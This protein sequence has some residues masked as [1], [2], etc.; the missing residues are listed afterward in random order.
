MYNSDSGIRS[1]LYLVYPYSAAVG[2]IYTSMFSQSSN[3]RLADSIGAQEIT[4]SSSHRQSRVGHT[5]TIADISFESPIYEHMLATL[6]NSFIE[7][8]AQ[9][10]RGE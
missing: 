5:T 3:M 1:F 4:C 2:L 8:G 6:R 10:R 9:I 7:T